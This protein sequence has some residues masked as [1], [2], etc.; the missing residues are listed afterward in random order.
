MVSLNLKSHITRV[1]GLKVWARFISKQQNK[2]LVARL[3]IYM[4]AMFWV[5]F[6]NLLF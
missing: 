6:F 4:D 1:L 3:P 2:A 5:T